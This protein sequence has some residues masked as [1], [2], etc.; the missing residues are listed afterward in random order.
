MGKISVLVYVW[1]LA[2]GL[3]CPASNDVVAGTE[4][5]RVLLISS[6]HPGFPTFFQ[7][8][9]GITS[10]FSQKGIL[11]DVEF[12]D[13]KR[14]ADAENEALFLELLSFKIRKTKPYDVVMTADD[15]ALLFMLKHR[16]N[17]WFFTRIGARLPRQSIEIIFNIS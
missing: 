16:T 7:Q 11:L 15:D 14:F 9:H 13:K 1:L 6:Y 5:T 12:M 17:L 4:P 10:V 8:V 2:I 3:L